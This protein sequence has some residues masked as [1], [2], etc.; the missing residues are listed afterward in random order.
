MRPAPAPAVP[1][2]P[3]PAG[4][5]PAAAPRPPAAA[6]NPAAP[7]APPATLL[8]IL[9]AASRANPPDQTMTI[10]DLFLILYDRLLIQKSDNCLILTCHHREVN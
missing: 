6:P 9:L 10:M 3:S 5:T 1:T 4:M 8:A 7:I 2:T